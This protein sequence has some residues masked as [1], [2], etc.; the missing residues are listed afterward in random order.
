[1]QSIHFEKVEPRKVELRPATVHIVCSR[2]GVW[3]WEQGKVVE[4]SEGNP[5]RP[6][7]LP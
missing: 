5:H 3:A 2:E 6:P 7:S 4:L 1:M